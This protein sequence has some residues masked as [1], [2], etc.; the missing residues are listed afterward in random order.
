[1]LDKLAATGVRFDSCYVQPLCTPTRTQI[2]TGMYNVRNYTDFGELESKNIDLRQYSQT[3]WLRNVHGRGNGNSEKTCIC[4]RN[5]AS[6]R[7]VSG[8]T[9]SQGRSLYESWS[10]HQW[11]TQGFH[12]QEYGPDIVSNLRARISFQ[13]KK[14]QPF[15]LYYTMMLTA[16][17]PYD[18][19]PTAP[20]MAKSS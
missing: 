12:E 17:L 3:G 20:T 16:T 7:I 19:T 6:T 2:M 8:I 10:R 15:F 11:R 14:D 1:V 5:S 13:R 18:A 9:H 4:P